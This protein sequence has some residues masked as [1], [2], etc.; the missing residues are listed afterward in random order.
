M[1]K[2]IWSRFLKLVNDKEEKY[3]FNNHKIFIKS[4]IKIFFEKNNIPWQNIHLYN[5]DVDVCYK[6][7]SNDIHEINLVFVL[8]N[9]TL[10]I[11]NR[12]E[13][14]AK[15][16]EYLIGVFKCELNVKIFEDDIWK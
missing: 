7:T 12:G 16:R 9:S 14:L 6:P 4:H 13:T 11:G 8:G 15:L 5:I 10:L 2:Y 1:K 3:L